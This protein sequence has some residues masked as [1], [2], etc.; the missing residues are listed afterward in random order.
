MDNRKLLWRSI[1]FISLL[2]FSTF[3]SLAQEK[4]TVT[5]KIL[6]DAGKPLKSVSVQDAT[7]MQR[8]HKLRPI[9]QFQ[10]DLTTV[11]GHPM[12]NTQKN[13]YQNQGYY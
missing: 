1:F 12:S 2:F 6:N 9:P 3:I 13:E 4:F 8:F 5:G 11:N 10:I 7:N